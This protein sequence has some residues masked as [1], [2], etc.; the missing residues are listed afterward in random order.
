MT[1]SIL[2]TKLY[3]PPTR[4][5]IVPRPRLIERL[6][7]GLHRKLTLISAPAGFGKTTLVSDWVGNMRKGVQKES[8][9]VNSAWLSLD[10]DDNNLARFLTY[11]ITALNRVAGIEGTIGEGA[12]GMLQSPQPPPTE[13]VLTSLINEISAFPGKIILVLDDYHSIQSSQV[14][15][16]LT[17][18]LEHVPA[19]LHVVVATR[20][21]PDL[22]LT[23]LRARGQMTELRVTDLRFTSSEAADYLNQV[24]DL[25]LSAEEVASLETRTE[26]WISGL[27]LAALS[28]RGRED[29][30]G[31]IRAFGG[32]NRYI[33]DYLIEEVLQRQPERV[34]TFLLQ[35][36]ILD[37]LSGP[38]CDAVTGQEDGRGMLEALERG[39]LFV[40]PLDDKRQWYRYHHLFADVLQV[41][42]M[43]E[44]PIHVPT[45]H[46]RASEWYEQNNSPPDAIRHALAAED[47]ERAA[48]LVELAWPAMD[49]SFQLATWL[50]WVQAL[51]DELIRAR[52]VL[53]VGYAWALLNGGEFEAAEV[54]LLDAERW[55]ETWADM[56]E[57]SEISSVE[58]V[59]V[60]EEQFRSLPVSLASAR[61]YHSQALGDVPGTV[62]YARRALDL[63]PEGDYF[64]RGRAAV[65]LGLAQWASGDLDA[66]HRSF[67]DAMASFQMAGNILFAISFTFILADIRMAQGRL[68]EAISTYEQSLHLAREQGEPVLQGTAD[69]YTGLS[70]MHREQGDLGTARQHLLR[71]G[72]LGEQDDVYLYRLC[73]AQARI[74]E[75]QGDLDGA[76]DQL[77]EA[78][79]H[80]LRGPVPDVRPVAALKTRVWVAQ[81]RLTEALGWTRAR[82]LSVDDDLS[83]LREFEH[84][85]LARVLI[86]QYKSEREERFVHDAMG[87][88]ER[89]LK[90]AEEGERMGSVIEILVQ[91]ALAHEAQGDI[92]PALVSLERALML[93]EPEGYVRIF[94]D[95]GMPMA[96]LLSAAAAHGIMPDYTG[97]LLAVFEAEQQKSENKSYLP[98]AQPLSEPLSQRELEV[99]Q[100]IAQGLS[101]REIGERLFLALSTVKGHNRIIF[102][103]LEVQRRTEAVARARELG[104]L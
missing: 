95:E 19:Q 31:F 75:S 92:P 47:F 22:P 11:F 57:R 54:R 64:A 72:E 38:L 86:A 60:D 20:E 100:L 74:K 9:I 34:R 40:V 30:P 12:L 81:G 73:R 97:K 70:E 82:G 66:A 62:K 44:Q 50:G 27:Q 42:S 67:A 90:A 79:R 85:T 25:N 1:S 80:Y 59:V 13:S 16:A 15:D 18:L 45:A 55:L 99:L 28:M 65:L 4:P 103:K 43:E 3:I 96:H 63:I 5:E 77:H 35:T 83:Y 52:P 101:N 26:G 68:H 91:Q 53:C 8:Q 93:A 7:E 56:G 61:A 76:L 102:G 87:L 104:L 33:V 39:N 69:L 58:M 41:R 84:V 37:R 24:M 17:F 6:D 98:P 51:P 78:E 2:V 23:R 48:A 71:I 21:D 10:E 36:S 14:D 49:E 88:L 29:I 89:L 94:I 46:R 32:D